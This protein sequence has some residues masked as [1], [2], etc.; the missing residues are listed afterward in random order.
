MASRVLMPKGS[1]TMTEGKVLKWL[2]NEGE[3]VANGDAL[4]EIETDKVDMEVESMA[5]GV[6]R[7]V[8]V[9]A[10]ETVPVGQMLAVIGKAEEDISSLISSNGGAA[11]AKPP[12]RPE[13]PQPESK[14]AAPPQPLARAETPAPGPAPTATPQQTEGGRLLASPLA[15][16]MA[17]DAGLDLSA[18][19]GSGPG[20]RII[21]RDV[22]SAS[23]ASPPAATRAAQ[24]APQGPEYR[25]EPLS[26]MRKTIAQ[27][28]AQSLGPVPHFYLTIDV[29]MKKAKELRESANK[30]N[31]DLKLTYNDI[32]V[33]ACAVALT[34]HPDVNASFT[35]NAIRYHNRVHLGIAVAIDGGGL[36]TPVVRDC[37]FKTLQQISAESKDLIAR[38]R[39]RKLK[40]EEYTGGTFSVS[41]L[42]MMG[43]VEFSAVI[44]PPEGAILAIGSVEEKPVVET[45]QIT[46]GFRCRMTLSCDHRVVDGAT[47]ARFLQ[48]L[49]QILEN[50]ILMAL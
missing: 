47:G 36:I 2:K 5:S 25:D 50:P 43:I 21:R 34:Q 48:S 39:T 35:G 44:N 3:Q 49:Q 13:K 22:E 38:A 23:S 7:K 45:G 29:D 20:G 30:L 19:Q 17:R 28:L 32:I 16:R 12:A 6:L 8:L 4:V 24:F 10:G 9:Q 46:V 14:Q 1:D 26:Q 37:N 33:K 41:N 18:I 42:G 27:R 40:P 31:P 15:R 11:A